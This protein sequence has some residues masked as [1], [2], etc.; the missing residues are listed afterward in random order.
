MTEQTLRAGSSR[1]RGFTLIEVVVALGVMAIIGV[2]SF[3]AL[4][5]SLQ[6]RDFLEEEEAFVRSA[7]TALSRVQRHLELAWLTSSTGAVNTFQTVFVAKDGDE[8]D[9]IWFNSLGHRRRHMNSRE[10]DETEITLWTEDDPENEG[11][12]VLLM[13]EAARIDERPEEEGAI[14]PL[15]HAVNRFDV[16]YLDPTTGEWTEEWDSTGTEQPARLPRAAQIV[17]VLMGPSDEDPEEK[18]ARTFVRT[19]QMAFA[20]TLNRDAQFMQTKDAA[21][22]V[23]P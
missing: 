7:N 1:R 17:L 6:A 15:A 23:A 11:Y 9:Q 8:L 20:Q 21:E 19:V 13:R 18:E 22:V 16:R 5:G 3:Q 14:L 2:M 4:S 12:H 10:C